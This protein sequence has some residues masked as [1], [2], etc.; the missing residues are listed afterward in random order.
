MSDNADTQVRASVW[1]NPDPVDALRTAVYRCRPESATSKRA[2]TRS[3]TTTISGLRVGELVALDVDHLREDNTKLYL[4]TDLKKDYP[5][6][7]R[8]R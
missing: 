7:I 3:S 1:L 4:P 5:N 6:D 8:R 2:T